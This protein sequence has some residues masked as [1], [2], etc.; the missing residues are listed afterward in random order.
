MPKVK[1][2]P[3]CGSISCEIK[4]TESYT[5]LYDFNG[6]PIGVTDNKVISVSKRV[7]CSVCNHNVTGLVPI[8]EYENDN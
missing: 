6:D 2:C 3:V 1:G 7:R 4:V 8:M 5:K